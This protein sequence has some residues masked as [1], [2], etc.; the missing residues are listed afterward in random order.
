MWLLNPDNDFQRLCVFCVSNDQI[1][2]I[3]KSKSLGSIFDEDLSGKYY[4]NRFFGYR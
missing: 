4:E 1:N 2:K 3:M